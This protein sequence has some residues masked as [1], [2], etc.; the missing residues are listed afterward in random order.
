MNEHEHQPRHSVFRWVLRVLY[1]FT[2][3]FVG[4]PVVAIVQAHGWERTVGLIAAFVLL[5]WVLLLKVV[6]I[7]K[8]RDF[9]FLVWGAPLGLGLLAGTVEIA[10]T[11]RLIHGGMCDALIILWILGPAAALQILG[12]VVGLLGL[13]V[14]LACAT[15]QEC[16]HPSDD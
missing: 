2:P 8:W 12:F 11:A 15:G 16:C 13:V 3:A 1:I 4:I 5:G 6:L 10:S 9:V 14:R 7:F